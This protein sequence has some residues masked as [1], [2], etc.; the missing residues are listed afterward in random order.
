MIIKALPTVVHYSVKIFKHSITIAKYNIDITT[1]QKQKKAT[2]D[3][4]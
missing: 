3:A 4:L 1:T 2:D